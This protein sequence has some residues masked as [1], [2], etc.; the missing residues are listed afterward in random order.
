ML[1]LLGTQLR[2]T[3]DFNGARAE[4]Q[5]IDAQFKESTYRDRAWFLL[6]EVALDLKQADAAIA[7]FRKVASDFPKSDRPAGSL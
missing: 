5:K 2:A 6:G 1:L 3:K 4:L 7:A